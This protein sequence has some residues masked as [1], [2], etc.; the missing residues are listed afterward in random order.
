[1]LADFNDSL[2]LLILELIK[3]FKLQCVIFR[4]VVVARSWIVHLTE[5][6]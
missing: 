5:I 6:F 2:F 4:N 3:A 1:M